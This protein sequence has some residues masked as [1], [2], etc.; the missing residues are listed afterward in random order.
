[1]SH[2]YCFKWVP[3][4]THTYI[5]KRA[6]AHTN[7]QKQLHTH[8]HG[9]S[10]R[11]CTLTIRHTENPTYTVLTQLQLRIHTHIHLHTK[12]HIHTWTLDHA[13]ETQDISIIGI[14]TYIKGVMRRLVFTFL[15]TSS[16]IKVIDIHNSNTE[17]WIN[18]LS[19]KMW[20]DFFRQSKE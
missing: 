11:H 1:M 10:N 17:R 3:K 7:T 8:T 2:Q 15:I 4:Y 16:F 12:I 9:H 18:N 14:L 20:Y 19:Q 5:Y 13:H 6:Y